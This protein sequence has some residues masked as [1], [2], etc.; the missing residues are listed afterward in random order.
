MG[1]AHIR[2]H[3]QRVRRMGG[4]RPGKSFGRVLTCTIDPPKVIYAP[5]GVGNSFQALEDGIACIY[6]ANARWSADMKAYAFMSL[7]DPDLGI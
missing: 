2:C 6:L 4:L 7:A 1:E 3:G 5:R